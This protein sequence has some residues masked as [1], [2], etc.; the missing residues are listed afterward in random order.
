MKFQSF[1]IALGSILALPLMAW[2]QTSTPSALA[3]SA[4][5]TVPALVPFAGVATGERE[6]PMSGTVTITFQ[7]FKAESGGEPLWAE[8]QTAVLD[9]T[10]QYKVQLGAASTNGIPLELFQSG[11]ARW[12]EAQ[13]AGRAPQARVLLSS[14]PY[15]IKAADAETLAGRGATDFVTQEQL[16]SQMAARQG[17]LGSLSTSISTQATTTGTGT[18]KFVPVWTGPTALGDSALYQAAGGTSPRMGINTTSPVTTLD[19]NGSSTVRGTLNLPS[20]AATATTGA[21][22]PILELSGSAF[23]SKT[24]TAAAQ[25]FAWQAVASGNDTTAPSANLNLLYGAGTA[26]P[27]ATGLAISPKGLITFS[28]GQTFPGA[29]NTIKAGYGLIS[30][31]TGNTQT[32]TVDGSL[33]PLLAQ[34]NTFAGTQTVNYLNVN[35]QVATASINATQGYYLDGSAFAFGSNLEA[36]AYLGFA[37]NQSDGAGTGNTG[38]GA[39]ALNL[40]SS[41][42][43][44]TALGSQA[45]LLDNAGAQNVAVG[46]DSLYGTSTG[47]DNTAIGTSALAN[48]TTGSNNTAL[49]DSAGPDAA[50]PKLA[51]STAIGANAIVSQSNSLVL[52]QTTAGKVGSSHVN[53]GIGTAIPATTMEIAVNA[54][55]ALG[56]TLTLTNPGGDYGSA[57]ID[58]KTYLHASTAHS[59]TARILVQDD[60]DYGADIQFFQKL[61]GA[62]SNP[63]LPNATFSASGNLEGLDVVTVTELDASVKHFKIDH[64]T[65][66]ANKFLVHSSVES[67]EMMNIYSGNVVTDEL[68][69]ATVKLPDW[70][71]AENTDFRYQLTAI[72]RDAHVWVAEEVGNGQFKVATNPSHVKVSWQITAV[73]QDAY[74]KAHPMV[75]EQPKTAKERGFYVHPEL[76]GQPAEK[77][78]GKGPRLKAAR[79]TRTDAEQAQGFAGQ[80]PHAVKAPTGDASESGHSH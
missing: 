23:N 29:G 9:A 58:F 79:A 19:I 74:A 21:N 11:E 62:D 63:L 44:N 68:G 36:N 38:V 56:P 76:Y 37:G 18:A 7:M 2:P 10:G 42:S 64:P 67:S 32:L 80:T 73:R 22:S 13:V 6:R 16:A 35:E 26:A 28:A 12:L 54:P 3:A 65:D 5:T 17:T 25:K 53:V 46:S 57:S 24:K 20:A 34:N 48:N 66:P 55:G 8:T 51:N 78:I 45:M 50:S 60:N 33:I 30:S 14:V 4:P 61:P 70:F 15:A 72:G 59:P 75:V 52:G 47:S 40:I 1:F 31:E 39:E 27:A 49:G 69:L 77:E 43:Y 71:E 41:G